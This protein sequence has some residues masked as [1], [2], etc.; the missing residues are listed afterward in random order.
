M[1]KKRIVFLGGKNIGAACL[2]FM[3]KEGYDIAAVILN[4]RELYDRQ[5]W[6]NS[7]AEVALNNGIPT[8]SFKT[9]NSR[10]A[11]HFL[12]FLS[13]DLMFSIFFDE[14]YSQDIIRIPPMGM[15]NLHMALSEEYRGRFPC[16]YTILN[17]EKKTGVTLHYID[18]G[19]DTGD[20]IG[21][22]EVQIDKADTASSLYNKCTVAGFELFKKYLASMI[23]GNAPRREQRTVDE[24]KVHTRKDLISKEIDFSKSGSEVYN[25]IRAWTF[26]PFEPPYFYIGDKKMII[27]PEEESDLTYYEY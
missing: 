27:I 24:V 4:P 21:T 25:F 17:R 19:V 1:E 15:I 22:M 2:R 13:P 14:I 3:L 10:E 6:Y 26:P 18:K 20:I 12:E 8:L 23:Q 7:T 11:I 9:I 5:R 16:N